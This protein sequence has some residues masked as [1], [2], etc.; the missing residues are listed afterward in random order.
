MKKQGVW[1]GLAIGLVLL[2]LL[3]KG[4]GASSMTSEEKRVA[5]VLSAIDGAGKVEV[6]LFYARPAGAFASDSE[7]S[8]S[9]AV[10]VA[11]GAGNMEVKLNLIRAVRTLLTLEESAVDVFVMEDGR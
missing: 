8:P 11:Q 1:I 2:T 7:G 6:A 10:V 5:Q 3:M 9:G 4:P